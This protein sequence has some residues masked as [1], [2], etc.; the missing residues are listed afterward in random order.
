[1]NWRGESWDASNPYGSTD[2]V[3]IANRAVE[4]KRTPFSYV[5]PAHSV[6]VLE[7]NSQ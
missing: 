2:N 6:T 1:M 3:N 5:F 7:L 4:A